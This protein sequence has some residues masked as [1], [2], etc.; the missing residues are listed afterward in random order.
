MSRFRLTAGWVAAIAAAVAGGVATVASSGSPEGAAGKPFR[1]Y[2]NT[3]YVGTPKHSSILVSSDYGYV[4]IDTGPKGAGAQVA[5]NIQALGF[6][7]T[8]L[9]AIVLSDTRP[10]HAGALGELVQL[11][12]AQVY[13]ARPGDEKLRSDKS[14]TLKRPQDDQREG[15]RMG[16]IPMLPHVWVVQDDQ[17]LSISSVRLRALAT[18]GGSPE[19]ISWTWDSCDGSKCLPT[20]Y[21]ASLEP[22][23]KPRDRAA[24]HAAVE[25]SLA[26]LERAPCQLLLTPDPA[27]A[28][29]LERLVK[30]EGKQD[31]LRNEGACKAYVQQ[32]REKPGKR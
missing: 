6:K 18:P 2:G 8:D 16:S 9:K 28:G 26:R 27:E 21:P 12:G 4:L 15:A 7:L 30:A 19:G 17:V 11:T 3:Y 23:G 24:A 25:T 22:A 20:V 13:T 31:V 29:G 1:I 32:L 14:F 5:A 10:E